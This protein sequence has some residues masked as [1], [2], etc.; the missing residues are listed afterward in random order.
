MWELVSECASGDLVDQAPRGDLRAVGAHGGGDG[1]GTDRHVRLEGAAERL[2]QRV[3][4]GRA[5]RVRG[6]YPELVNSLCPVVL[7][8]DLGHHDLRCSSLRGYRDDE[9]TAP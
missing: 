6:S 2:G 7:V 5:G 8:I 1:S 4:G 3:G 9:M